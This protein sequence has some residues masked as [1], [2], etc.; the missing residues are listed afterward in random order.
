MILITD[1]REQTGLEFPVT[2]GVSVVRRMM[3]AGDYGAE[4]N[5]EMVKATVERKSINDL[6]A[7]F[8][9]NYENEKAK[10]MRAKELGWQY[11][12]AIEAPC[13]EVRKGHEYR[14]DGVMVASKKSGLAQVRQ[15]MTLQAK[16]GVQVW[17]CQTRAEMAFMVMEY[18]LA[19]ERLIK[20][21]EPEDKQGG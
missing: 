9:N 4:V 8:S 18:F 19:W 14:K 6:F 2:H 16:Y 15:L 20:G 13:F 3:P 5:G 1:T 11:V 17:W 12:L 7:N 21:S 10:L